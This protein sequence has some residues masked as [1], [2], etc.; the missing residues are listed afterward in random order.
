VEDN[1]ANLRLVQQILK[2]REEITMLSADNPE[3]GLRLAIE[4]QPDLILL[5]INLPGMS[6]FDVLKQLR[7]NER[8]AGIP[9]IA[10]SANAMPE[11]VQRGIDAGFTHYLTK[12][13]SIQAFMSALDDVLGK[14]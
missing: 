5:D 8:T 9:A 11:D 13:I 14:D 7:L 4:N 6:G 1:P 2:R 10:I 12:P 3:D